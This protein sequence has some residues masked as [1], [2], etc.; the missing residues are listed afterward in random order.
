MSVYREIMRM[1]IYASFSLMVRGQSNSKTITLLQ[2]IR[3]FKSLKP[4]K[5]TRKM[6]PNRADAVNTDKAKTTMPT[7]Q[8]VP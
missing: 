6:M 5:A 1:H 3:L 7:I 4:A 8:R 2:Y